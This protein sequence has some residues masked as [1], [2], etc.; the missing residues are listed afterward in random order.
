MATANDLQNAQETLDKFL[1]GEISAAASFEYQ[2]KS[3]SVD[4]LPALIRTLEARLGTERGRSKKISEQARAEA[5]ARL[6]ATRAEQERNRQALVQAK[7]DLSAAKSNAKQVGKDFVANKASSADVEKANAALKAA[8]DRVAV[9]SGE[10]PAPSP[11]APPA[12]PRV[13]A[14][15]GARPQPGVTETAATEDAAVTGTVAE[16][17]TTTTTGATGAG[18]KGTTGKGKKKTKPTGPTSD[19]L[20]LTQLA[21]RFPAYRDWSSADVRAYFG[22]DM[23]NILLRINNPNHPEG[24]LDS[25]TTDG[26][27]GIERLIRQTGYWLKT[28]KAIRE[29]DAL[30]LT[31]RERKVKDQKDLL[32]QNFGDLALNDAALTDIATQIVRTGQTEIGAKQL[33]YAKAF[34]RAGS[35]VADSRAMALQ[36]ADADRIRQ[37]V[38]AYGMIPTDAEI[39]AVLTG[40]PYGPGKVVL[41]EDALVQKAQAAA[42]GQYSHLADQIDSGLTL[43]D[44]FA[45]YKR[46]AASILQK[47]PSEINLTD[48]L[49]ASA[50]GTK[51]TGQMSLNDWTRMLKSDK[52]YGWQ[53]TDEAN[54]QVNSVVSTLERAFGLVK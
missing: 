15:P 12:G 1:R 10:K 28:E 2:G 35:T 4:E 43:D 45:N 23:V 46:Y 9:L 48:P 32:A 50:L 26:K 5:G 41:T 20:L 31:A 38:R 17:A 47:D 25:T 54:Q 34:Q 19:E 52:R 16:T 44:I 14:P 8:E 13:A 21:E 7:T 29:W 37:S 33:V 22:E 51:E 27:A 49:Y 24:A 40:Q 6:E 30:D 3:Y 11:S 53:Y 39:E 18:G 36:G 42:K